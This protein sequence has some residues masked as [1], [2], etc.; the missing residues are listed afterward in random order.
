MQSEVRRLHSRAMA[1]DAR[2][3]WNDVYAR[4]EPSSVSWFQS[5]PE[6]SLRLILEAVG[7]LRRTDRPARIIDAGGGASTLVDCMLESGIDA[8]ICVID[9]SPLALK[10]SRARL[11]ARGGGVR[12]L[13]AD[14]ARPLAGIEPGWADVWHDRAAFHFLTTDAERGVYAGNIRRVLSPRGTVIIAAFAPDGPDKCSGLPVAGQDGGSLVRAF[15]DEFALLR[16]EREEHLTPRGAAQPFV[17][18]VMHRGGA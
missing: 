3:H 5:R 11:G 7:T 16:E 4:K 13:E 2:A 10:D 15:G 6:R 12:W 17:Y 18:S 8:E 1:L 14:L 9:I